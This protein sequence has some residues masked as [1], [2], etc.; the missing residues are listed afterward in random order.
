MTSDVTVVSLTHNRRRNVAELL[1]TLRRQ[2]Y[3]SFE[4]I[5]IDNA[6]TDGTPDMIRRQ[7]PEV[8]LIETETNL[9]MVAYNLGFEAA[10]GEYILV[11]DDDGLPASD[12]W[13]A[14][15]VD[16]FQS[17]PRLGA[18]S[19]TVRMRDSG[20]IAHDSPQFVP[21]GDSVM[22]YPAAAYN[23]TGAGLRASALLQ[24]RLYP[25]HFFR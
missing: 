9:G 22:G 4:I 11:M 23:G 2:T 15:V 5:L 17:N 24:T 25:W 14:K 13:I 16:R 3:S 10:Q 21:E 7:F 20:R 8:R 18:L 19:C 12:D 6:S 1:R